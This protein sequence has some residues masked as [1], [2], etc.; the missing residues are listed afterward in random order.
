VLDEELDRKCETKNEIFVRVVSP[1][2]AGKE[3][4]PWIMYKVCRQC[5]Q[6]DGRIALERVLPDLGLYGPVYGEAIPRHYPMHASACL[7]SPCDAIKSQGTMSLSYS[8]FPS[9]LPIPIMY[10]RSMA[11]NEASTPIPSERGDALR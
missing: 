8:P 10:R 3:E 7:I 11:P 2:Q 5:R 1:Q 6:Q 4:S 9:R